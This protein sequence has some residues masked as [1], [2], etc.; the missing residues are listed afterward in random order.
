VTLRAGPEL[1]WLMIM[2]SSLREE[3]ACCQGFAFG[4]QCAVQAAV[5]PHVSVALAYRQLHSLVPAP[6]MTFEDVER[7]L[8]ARIAGDF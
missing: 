3:E 4:G 1:Q 8:T 7:F 6:D 5:G 2:S